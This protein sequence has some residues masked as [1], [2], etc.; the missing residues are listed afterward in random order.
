MEET[1]RKAKTHKGRQY[2]QKFESQMLENE[3]KT[4][5]LKGQRSSKDSLFA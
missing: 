5:F 4:L 3:R 1:L 2:L